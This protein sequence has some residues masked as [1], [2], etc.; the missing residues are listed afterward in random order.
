MSWVRDPD[1]SWSGKAA[2]ESG[3][4]PEIQQRNKRDSNRK[5]NASR[6]IS[7]FKLPSSSSGTLTKRYWRIGGGG[8]KISSGGIFEASE[9]SSIL[10]PEPIA[11]LISSDDKMSTTWNVNKTVLGHCFVHVC[12]ISTWRAMHNVALHKECGRGEGECDHHEDVHLRFEKSP[13]AIC[14]RLQHEVVKQ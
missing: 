11:V 13:F 3:W 5:L 7:K 4:I 8:I 2:S 10:D 14:Q 9:S 12:F 6:N 1:G